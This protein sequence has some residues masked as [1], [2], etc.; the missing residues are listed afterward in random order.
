[1]VT[2]S[3]RWILLWVVALYFAVWNAMWTGCDA[4]GSESPSA[5]GPKAAPLVE[6]S[7]QLLPG[8]S[9]E[10]RRVMAFDHVPLALA[11]KS[12]AKRGGIVLEMPDGIEGTVNGHVADLTD[13]QAIRLIVE[14]KGW[15]LVNEYKWFRV[16]VPEGELRPPQKAPATE[17]RPG[18][19]VV[20]TVER[21]GGAAVGNFIF[22]HAP[23]LSTL[24][25]IAAAGKVSMLSHPEVQGNVTLHLVGV[26]PLEALDMILK[27]GG[28]ER[29]EM[30]G[31]Q[32]IHPKGWTP[33]GSD[34]GRARVARK[35][36]FERGRPRK[37]G[38]TCPIRDVLDAMAKDLGRSVIIATGVSA[39]VNARLENV[40]GEVAMRVLIRAY[41][42]D[43]HEASGVLL[44]HE[45]DWVMPE[46]LKRE[47]EAAPSSE[48]K[49]GS[50]GEKLEKRVIH[51]EPMAKVLTSLAEEAGVSLL[52][53]CEMREKVTAR[54]YG[55]PPL[56]AM[57]LIVAAYGYDLMERD[58]FFMVHPLG[59]KPPEALQE[60][61]ESDDDEAC[62]EFPAA[63]TAKRKVI[64]VATTDFNK[65]LKE[66]ASP[67]VV[68]PA[69]DD[70]DPGEG[71]T[72]R[73]VSM[74]PARAL[75]ILMS[76]R[77]SFFLEPD[78][79]YRFSDLEV[80]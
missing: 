53:P 14:K 3:W 69:A 2:K 47:M 77:E 73:F 79:S 19:I 5:V 31:I 7:E 36:A 65:A 43:Y 25:R 4:V 32:V 39:D 54:F 66:I 52:I 45:A 42:F 37:L 41:D 35:A 61:V 78:G 58:G 44:V 18:P 20:R 60:A 38:S 72:L 48:A 64:G 50:A 16:D 70:D 67:A 71:L 68:K 10:Q 59:W 40:P 1:M 62:S 15:K 13:K 63:S 8:S 6:V 80:K 9:T 29:T 49:D 75:R 28:F 12:L 23:L 22:D 76:I 51:G 56:R 27:S 33:A 17:A 30:S 34:D 57:K 55:V 74:S 24:N 21:E 11:L 26:P 46:F